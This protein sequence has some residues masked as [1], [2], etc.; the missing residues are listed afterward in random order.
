MNKIAFEFLASVHAAK[1]R[2]VELAEAGMRPFR[3]AKARAF[4]EGNDALYEME[5]WITLNVGIGRRITV[6]GWQYWVDAQ[7]G[8][9]CEQVLTLHDI[10]E[11]KPFIFPNI[12][13]P[14]L[15]VAIDFFLEDETSDEFAAKIAGVIVP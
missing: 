4:D 8:I 2:E 7:D 3:E 15:Q 13:C 1:Q 10:P 5:E 11:A 14:D 9:C 12:V 6:E